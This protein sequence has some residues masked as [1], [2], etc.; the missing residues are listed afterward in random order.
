V[1]DRGH[2]QGGLS[3]VGREAELGRLDHFVREA[4]SGSS[5]VLV[6]APGIGKTTLW[7]AASAA[8]WW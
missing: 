2:S 5:I 8:R 3:V 7:E 1:D 4:R 6:G